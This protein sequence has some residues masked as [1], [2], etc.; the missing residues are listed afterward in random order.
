MKNTCQKTWLKT[1]LLQR[2]GLSRPDGRELFRYRMTEQEFGDLEKSLQ[3]WLAS[4]SGFDNLARLADVPL[5]YKLFVLYG[6]EWWRRRYDGS[7]FSWEPILHDLRAD[8]DAWNAMQRSRCVK[9]GLS[10]WR[11]KVRQHGGCDIFSALPCRAVC[12]CVFL[13]RGGAASAGS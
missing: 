13:P 6:A 7:G 12:L 1:F 5:F 4:L 10:S 9:N 11:V 3:S 8:P 2:G